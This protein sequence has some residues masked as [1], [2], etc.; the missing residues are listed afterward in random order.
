M[1]APGAVVRDFTMLLPPGWARIPLD[2]RVP[3]RVRSLVAERLGA[4]PP[5]HRETLR[6]GLTR[7]LT[8]VLGTAARKGGIDVLLSVDP[9]AGQPVPAS[10]VVSVL[11]GRGDGDALDALAGT[12]VASTRSRAVREV[13]VVEIAGA[14]A[15]RRLTDRR[16]RVEPEAGLAGGVLSITQVDYF[17]PLPGGDGLL[18]LTFSTPVEAL[19]PPLVKLFDVMA[20]SFRWVSR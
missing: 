9:V 1:T 12:L 15:V 17:V 2:D 18:V 6:T 13:G 16:E 20:S 3:L 10:A 19:G 7:E 14:P 11:E 5:E 8:A 4:A